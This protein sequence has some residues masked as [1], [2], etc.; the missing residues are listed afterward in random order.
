MLFH[1]VRPLLLAVLVLMLTACDKPSSDRLAAPGDKAEAE[2][3]MVASSLWTADMPDFAKKHNCN[4]CHAIDKKVVGP[5]WMDVSKRYKGDSNAAA[6]LSEK[7]TKGGGG[8]WGSMPMPS[9]PK[10]SDAEKKKLVEFI[11][12]LAK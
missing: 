4:A 2:K 8:A 12:G 3:K 9:N 5:S 6:K 7:I 10:V 1:T 11:L